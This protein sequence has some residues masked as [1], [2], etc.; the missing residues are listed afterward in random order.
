MRRMIGTAAL[1]AAMALA[2]PA[3]GQRAATVQRCAPAPAAPGGV[4]SSRASA[5]NPPQQGE[6]DVVLDVPN[7]CV[8]ELQLDVRNLAAHLS[9]NARVANLV[10]VNAGA[11]VTIGNVSL[12]IRGV[13]AQA[14][15]LVD[16]DNVVYVVDRTLAFIDGNPAFVTGLF[17]TAQGAL[18][19]VGDLGTRALGPDGA[20]AEGVGTLGRELD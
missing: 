13:R 9:L 6:Y 15:L 2:T 1:F 17:R 19:T 10:R 16:L 7:L 8:D 3:A 18:S 14:L 20:V 11:D 5:D 12:G 4:E